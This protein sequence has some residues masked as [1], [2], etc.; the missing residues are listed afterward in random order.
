MNKKLITFRKKYGLS[1]KD[2]ADIL[3]KDQKTVSNWETGATQMHY[4]YWDALMKWKGK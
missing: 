3:Q 2:V 4:A 1:Q